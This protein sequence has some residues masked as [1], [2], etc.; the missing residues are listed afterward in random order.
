MDNIINEI[1]Y[2][3]QVRKTKAQKNSFIGYALGKA[4]E[5]GWDA[6]VEQGKFGARNIVVGDPER[7]K[8][9]YTAHYDT[10]PVLPFPNFITPKNFSVYLLYNCLIILAAMAVC[11]VVG[12]VWGVL[13]CF[14]N[15]D[16]AIVSPLFTLLYWVLLLLLLFGPANKH[17]A[18][19]NTSGVTVLF[20]IMK[21]MPQELRESTAII[22]FDLEEVGLIGSASYSGAHKNVKK[23]K[24]LLN[25][26]CVSDGDNI[27]LLLKKDAVQYKDKIESAF[28]SRE[29]MNVI[30]TDKAFYPSDQ[31]NYKMGV[32]V[33]ALKKTKR[34]M[35]YM[36]KIHTKNDTVFRRENI[37]FLADGAIR[38]SASL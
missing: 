1:F 10:C 24:L 26:D 2:Y 5:L 23:N 37:D 14:L 36:D 35:L 27:M 25:F 38:L 4:Q 34:G 16:P 31:A 20:G 32:G 12:V 29:D 30:V 22:F 9:V 6:H 11:V 18:N 19:D 17:T 3:Y 8:V 13:S 7:A 21:N 33:A 28:V 15:I